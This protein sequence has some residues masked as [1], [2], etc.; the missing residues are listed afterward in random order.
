MQGT[1]SSLQ[2]FVEPP[3]ELYGAKE[4]RYRAGMLTASTI[5]PSFNLHTRRCLLVVFGLQAIQRPGQDTPTHLTKQRPEVALK[6]HRLLRGWFIM[7][8]LINETNATG[9]RA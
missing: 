9:E 1:P 3:P 6:G 2:R 8:K 5:E 7:D 4:R